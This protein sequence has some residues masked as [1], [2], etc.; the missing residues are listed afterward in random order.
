MRPL[1]PGI[2]TVVYIEILRKNLSEPVVLR[3][4]ESN[5]LDLWSQPSSQQ[6]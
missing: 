4:C 6:H 2:K 5:P 3:S 1:L